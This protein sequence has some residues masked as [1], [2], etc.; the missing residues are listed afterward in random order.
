[1]AHDYDCVTARPQ[2]SQ[3]GGQSDCCILDGDLQ[4]ELHW[5][6]SQRD[7]LLRHRTLYPYVT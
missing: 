1:M 3:I 4:L 7:C 5:R 2:N 6:D